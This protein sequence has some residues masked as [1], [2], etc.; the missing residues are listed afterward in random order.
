M[1]PFFIYMTENDEFNLERF[2]LAQ[3][4]TYS[5]ALSEIER[6]RKT[7][8]WM[9]FIFPQVRGLGRSYESQLYGLDGLDE[10]RAYLSHETLGS[11]L[12]ECVTVLLR[13]ENRTALEIFGSIDEM[14]L[15]SSLTLFEAASEEPVFGSALKKFFNRELD[16]KTLKI[17][18]LID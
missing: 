6:G 8:H 11:R 17:L 13:V 12:K 10:A 14:K 3:R 15:R 9:W 2:V 4:N 18:G 5:R 16:Q 1:P 7:S